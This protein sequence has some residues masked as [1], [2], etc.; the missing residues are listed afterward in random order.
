MIFFWFLLLLLVFFSIKHTLTIYLSQVVLLIR[1]FVI[2]CLLSIYIGIAQYIIFLFEWHI[3]NWLAFN[4][5]K[6]NLLL[7]KNIKLNLDRMYYVM[8]LIIVLSTYALNYKLQVR[9]VLLRNNLWEWFIFY[10]NAFILSLQAWIFGKIFY[11]LY[12]LVCWAFRF[13]FL[14][15]INDCLTFIKRKIDADLFVLFA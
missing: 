10:L 2:F 11:F 7:L 4:N 5:I 6:I 12:Y 1:I 13:F 9:K 15:C 8:I 14:S 3:I